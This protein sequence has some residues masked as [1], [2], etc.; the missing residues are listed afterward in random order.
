VIAVPK[1]D[2]FAQYQCEPVRCVDLEGCWWPKVRV[3]HKRSGTVCELDHVCW[4]VER[5]RR[6]KARGGEWSRP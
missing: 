2:P 3:E 1:D 6:V 5:E 4:L